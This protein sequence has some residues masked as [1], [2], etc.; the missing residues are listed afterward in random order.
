MG[1]IEVGTIYRQPVVN[2]LCCIYP[3]VI[4]PTRNAF[5]PLFWL[6][7]RLSD[8]QCNMSRVHHRAPTMMA[9]R[10]PVCINLNEQFVVFEVSRTVV[11]ILK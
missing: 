2:S 9:A 6:V 5:I 4:E 10:W 7:I 3:L 11:C 1:S 8:G